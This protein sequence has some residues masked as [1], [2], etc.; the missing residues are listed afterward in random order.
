M[1]LVVAGRGALRRDP[2]Q[3][4]RCCLTLY[5]QQQ[6]ASAVYPFSEPFRRGHLSNNPLP[7]LCP[8][9]PLRT[10]ESSTGSSESPAEDPLP[11]A[12]PSPEPARAP[13][14]RGILVAGASG[15]SRASAGLTPKPPRFPSALRP[16]RST[17]NNSGFW[18]PTRPVVQ[19]FVLPAA[20]VTLH[21]SQSAK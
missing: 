17:L 10:W 20:A 15:A 2:S 12:E 16:P 3:S 7:A 21:Y 14:L 4:S 11:P 5:Y 9:A 19:V 1:T 13:L 18:S 6:A 8:R